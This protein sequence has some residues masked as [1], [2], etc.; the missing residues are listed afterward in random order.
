MSDITTVFDFVKKFL[1][2]QNA[3]A[4]IMEDYDAFR[5]YYARLWLGL[6]QGDFVG[7]YKKEALTYIERLHPDLQT[8]MQPEDGGRR[9]DRVC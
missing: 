9:F 6:V 5:E 2:S 7:K 8:R 3:D 4:E 1:E